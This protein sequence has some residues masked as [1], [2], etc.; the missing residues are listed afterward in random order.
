MNVNEII[1]EY[2]VLPK[3]NRLSGPIFDLDFHHEKY[4]KLKQEAIQSQICFVECEPPDYRN[5]CNFIKYHYPA[6]LPETFQEIALSIQEDLAIHRM[7]DDK[8]WMAAGHICFP[9]HWKP[10]DKI[11]KS[12]TEIHQPVPGM[13][14]NGKKL[15]KSMVFFGPFERYV[16][17]I[18]F[19][20]HINGHPS[21]P[22]KPFE[23]DFWIKIERQV[24]IGFPEESMALFT[25]RQYLFS[26]SEID[27]KILLNS[28]SRMTPAE[29]SYKGIP[30]NFIE[31][32]QWK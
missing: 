22:R 27:R 26:E 20:E 8:D 29:K 1:K 32:L 31:T 23:K 21:R 19:E 28:L 24:T 10:E 13:R 16:W 9:S 25:I 15:V 3:L 7:M 18:T 6:Q 12:F 30:E 14:N 5:I 17:G 11:G 4:L 2:S